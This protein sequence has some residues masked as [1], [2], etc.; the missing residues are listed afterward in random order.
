MSIRAMTVVWSSSLE[1]TKKLVCLCMADFADDNG[2][3][4]FPT[5]QTIASKSS[6]SVR[7]AQRIIHSLVEDGIVRPEG[8][9]SRGVP[10]YRLVFS[11]L[12]ALEKT[13]DKMSPQDNDLRQNVTPPRQIDTP[14]VTSTTLRGDT[15]MSPDPLINH[16]LNNQLTINGPDEKI[17]DNM[18]VADVWSAVIGQLAMDMSKAAFDTWVKHSSV[19]GVQEKTMLVKTPNSFSRD[20]LETRMTT[21]I[22]RML[23]GITNGAVNSA[24]FITEGTA[25]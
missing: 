1:S 3:N 4:I 13:C 9:T 14:G 2:G 6:I 21:T 25:V 24:K 10:R 15:A 8:S 11:A 20:W 19:V 7:T 17:L 18:T 23:N 22:N 5:M 16:Q 12:S